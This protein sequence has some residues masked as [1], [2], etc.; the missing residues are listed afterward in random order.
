MYV[1][2]INEFASPVPEGKEN[3]TGQ[4]FR[5][6]RVYDRADI[7][8]YLSN[9]FFHEVSKYELSENDDLE[10]GEEIL[11]KSLWDY[12]KEHKKPVE[13]VVGTINID[14]LSKFTEEP[15]HITKAN[16]TLK[17]I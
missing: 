9:E 12:L 2:D 14:E 5:F 10:P 4:K 3:P 6:E 15:L 8:K 17:D 11:E 1:R 13:R 7:F 16:R